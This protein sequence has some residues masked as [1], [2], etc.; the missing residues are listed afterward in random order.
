MSNEERVNPIEHTQLMVGYLAARAG[1]PVLADTAG[2]QWLLHLRNETLHTLYARLDWQ[3]LHKILEDSAVA[4]MSTAHPDRMWQVFVD[5]EGW[6]VDPHY[7]GITEIPPP[8]K[9]GLS[10]TVLQLLHEMAKLYVEAIAEYAYPDELAAAG[11]LRWLHPK[12]GDV[13]EDGDEG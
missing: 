7:H 11:G 13:E 9:S 3:D 5:V 4:S 10:R 6:M 1:I 2:W 12:R 8:E